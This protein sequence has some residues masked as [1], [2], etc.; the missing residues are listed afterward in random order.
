MLPPLMILPMMGSGFVPTDSTVS[1][2][3]L[4]ARTEARLALPLLLK[5][6]PG[7]RRAGEAPPR[8]RLTFRGYANLPVI[9]GD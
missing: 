4:L 1:P 5:R 3:R 8:D 7:M 9:C 2:S 6:L